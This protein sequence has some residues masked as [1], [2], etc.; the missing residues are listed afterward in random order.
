MP[1]PNTT[2]ANALR[3]HQVRIFRFSSHLAGDVQ[4]RISG[5]RA[6]L[7]RLV[8]QGDPTEPARQGDRTNRV[9]AITSEARK[10]VAATYRGVNT[11]TQNQLA[12][13]ADIDTA[14]VAQILEGQIGRGVQTLPTRTMSR[15]IDRALVDGAPSSDWWRRQSGDVVKRFHDQINQGMRAGES[16]GQLIQRVRGTRD[17]NYLDGVLNGATFANAEALVRSSVMSATNDLRAAEFAANDDVVAGRMV[18]TT[19]DTRT[20]PRC[21]AFAGGI[22]DHEGNPLPESPVQLRLPSDG[23]PLH[24]SCRCTWTVYLQGEA[25]PD[26]TFEAWLEDEPVEVQKEALGPQWW[27]AWKAGELKD[28]HDLVDQRGR[29]MTLKAL[30]GESEREAA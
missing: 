7:V 26:L 11:Y 18:L 3:R 5:V 4:Q 23:L 24:F 28:L 6:E 12:E 29:P 30:R 20:C 17:R 19:F 16:V 15:I 9:E 25:A 8:A 1:T 14:A 22:Y 2:L 27:A 10:S 13:L 21:M